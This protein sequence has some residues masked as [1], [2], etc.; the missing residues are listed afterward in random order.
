M[1]AISELNRAYL[2]LDY[3]KIKC[4]QGIMPLCNRDTNVL[5]K[6]KFL[7]DTYTS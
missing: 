3:E 1:S 4:T 2:N 6:P 5:G 7:S